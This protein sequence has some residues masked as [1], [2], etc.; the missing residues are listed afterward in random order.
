MKL[1]GSAASQGIPHIFVT[2]RF[3][4]VLTSTR[5]LSLS[6]AN[7][8]QSPQ[9]P[10]TSWRSILIL[11]SHLRL[12]LPSGLFPS[13]FRTRNLYT[14]LPCPIRATCPAH[15]ILLSNQLDALF[16]VFIS[17]LYMFRTTQCSSSGE[18]IVS[19]HHLVYIT[20]CSWP[21]GMQVPLWPAYQTTTYTEWYTGCPRRNGQNFGECSLCWTIPI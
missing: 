16:N 9:P 8:I 7:Y 11:Y 13:G 19:I 15:L 21:S 5:H 4:T 6:W 12:G 10:L 14:P 2:R 20:L 18:S 3:I 1:T 17:L